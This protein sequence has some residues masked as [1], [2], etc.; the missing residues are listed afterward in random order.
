[1]PQSEALDRLCK[2]CIAKILLKSH[3]KATT[4]SPFMKHCIPR[5]CRQRQYLYC[6]RAFTLQT[7]KHGIHAENNDEA[8]GFVYIRNGTFTIAVEGDGISPAAQLQID[9]GTFSVT[10]GGGSVTS[11]T[12]LS[13]AWIAIARKLWYNK[14]AE[15]FGYLS[16]TAIQHLRKERHNG[17]CKNRRTAQTAAQ[18]ETHDPKGSCL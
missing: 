9:G 6:R 8:L 11:E 12:K 13:E 18:R 14:A 3:L 7:G 2:E 4:F 10:T 1:M 16:G 15:K 5:Y 17:S